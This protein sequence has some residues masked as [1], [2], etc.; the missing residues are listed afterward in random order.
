M[1]NDCEIFGRRALMNWREIN[2]NLAPKNRPQ[3]RLCLWPE[4]RKGGVFGETTTRTWRK[5][6][7]LRLQTAVSDGLA[8][9]SKCQ[10]RHCSRSAKLLLHCTHSPI[11]TQRSAKLPLQLCVSSKRAAASTNSSAFLLPA[12]CRLKQKH[13]QQQQQFQSLF[14]TPFSSVQSWEPPKKRLYSGHHMRESPLLS[15]TF[16]HLLLKCPNSNL[17]HLASFGHHQQQQ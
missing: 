12:D 1:N 7:S 11:N 10:K 6:P 14:T 3:Y 8:F 9:A 4:G 16:A 17:L 5:E 13:S 2:L 15:Q